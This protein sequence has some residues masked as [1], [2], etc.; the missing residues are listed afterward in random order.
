MQGDSD[1]TRELLEQICEEKDAQIAQK[2]AILKAEKAKVSE[3]TKKN[4]ALNEQKQKLEVEKDDLEQHV[5]QAE[6]KIKGKKRGLLYYQ[7]EEILNKRMQTL[8]DLMK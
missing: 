1:S 2:K 7:R 6:A 4:R 5:D 3:L 8:T